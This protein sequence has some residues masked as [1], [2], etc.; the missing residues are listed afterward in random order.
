MKGKIK[1]P[2]L[3]PNLEKLKTLVPDGWKNI[4]KVVKD[5]FKDIP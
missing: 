3:D 4:P 1:G 2:S 5:A